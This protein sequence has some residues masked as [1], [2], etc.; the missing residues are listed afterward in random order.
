MYRIYFKILS[1]RINHPNCESDNEKQ[2]KENSSGGKH[3]KL[4]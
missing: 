3:F 4:F 2:N 1:V